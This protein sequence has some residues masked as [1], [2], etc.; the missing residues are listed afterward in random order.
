MQVF[1]ASF[2]AS[3]ANVVESYLATY[4]NLEARDR[5]AS[6]VSQSRGNLS[7]SAFADL[8]GV[9]HTSVGSWEKGTYMPDVKSLLRI[10]ERLGM[11]VEEF[12]WAVEG[13]PKPKKLDEMVDKIKSL[14]LK[15]LAVVERA[16]SDRLF[17]IAE[18]AGR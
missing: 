5:L 12:V 3:H 6:L 15:Q 17:A 18:S 1:Q 4:M 13:K 14:P 7:K 16:V 11:T 10:S 2:H 8:L 9:S